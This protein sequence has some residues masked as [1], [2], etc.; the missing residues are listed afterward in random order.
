MES[1]CEK[2]LDV[3]ALYRTGKKCCEFI[4]C[5]ADEQMVSLHV[6]LQPN[7]LL[8]L[9]VDGTAD[10]SQVHCSLKKLLYWLI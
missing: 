7:N 4:H 1:M 8:S 10:S 6:Q 5:I 2:G 3:G 9:M